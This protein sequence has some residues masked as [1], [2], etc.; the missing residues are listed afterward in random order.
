[1]ASNLVEWF[2]FQVPGKI[3]CAENSVDSIGMEMDKLGCKRA[4][5]VTDEGVEGA[6]LVEMVTDGLESGSIEF[7]G[8]FNEV[9]PNSEIGIVQSCYE[10]ARESGADCLVSIGGGSVMDTAKGCA[11]LMVEGG[12][13]LDHQS[14]VY[15]PS[16]SMPVHFAVPTTAG[17][18]SESTFAAVIAD[19]E[20]QLKLIFQ[21]P[22]LAPTVAMLDPLMTM[23]L[24]PG[25]TAATGMDALTH[26]IEALH[27]E[28]HEPICDGLA[29]H[30]I[31][32]ISEY[33]PRAVKDGEDVE[34]RTYMLIAA[35]MGGI[36]FAN[37]FVGIIHAMAHALGGRFGTP[38]GVANT[39]FLPHGMEFNLRY[40]EEGIPGTYK[41]VAEAMGLDVV[42]VD[43]MEAAKMAIDRIIEFTAE[44]DLPQRLSELDVP[45]EGLEGA[46]EDAMLDG[47]M[48]NN[49]GEPEYEEVLELFKK[50]Y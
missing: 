23:T 2:E 30:G 34:A 32:L 13:L 16:G 11:L 37:A 39:V 40:Q 7:A 25:L 20:Q 6:G 3:V 14:A 44:I 19:H 27:S 41:R 17:T 35:N 48:F 38:H 21:G 31:R 10:R 24:P 9:L 8:V 46:A 29:L 22:D 18:G 43:E 45:E 15:T 50:A 28:M 1:M 42:A 26:C 4:L 5:V 12:K 47:S 36:S 49:P 33:L